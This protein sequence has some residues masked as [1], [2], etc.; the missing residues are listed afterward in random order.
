MKL[1][2]IKYQV[3]TSKGTQL[4]EAHTSISATSIEVAQRKLERKLKGFLNGLYGS[5]TINDYSVIGYY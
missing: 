2:Y 4:Q 1:Y 5:L 3:R